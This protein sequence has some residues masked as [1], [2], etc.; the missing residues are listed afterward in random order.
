MLARSESLSM[1]NASSPPYA[2]HYWPT[3]NG[4]KITMMLE[5][6]EQPYEI[7]PVNIS[8]GDQFKPEF[9][10]LSPNNRMP[11]L[12]DPAPADGGEALSLFESG[13]IL[14]HIAASSPALVPD[15][16]AARARAMAWVFAALNSQHLR[17][18]EALE[19]RVR[20]VEGHGHRHFAV[21]REPLVGQVEMQREVQAARR[22]FALQLV[23]ARLHH[24]AGERDRQV[25]Q[26]Q[27]EERLV[28]Q[29]GPVRWDGAG[30]G[31]GARL[32]PGARQRYV[33]SV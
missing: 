12:V 20:Q 1:T 21:G 3:P 19:P 23:N 11:A 26:S 9:L 18:L 10:A 7:H 4:H 6:L 27:V 8:A 22:E 14:L 29:V 30:H 32:L 16:P 24:G 15:D 5:E 28:G 17:L 31:L 25:L 13:A 2:L 33:M